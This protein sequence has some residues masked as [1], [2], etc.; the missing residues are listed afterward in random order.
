MIGVMSVGCAGCWLGVEATIRSALAGLPL[1]PSFDVTA[2][3]VFVNVPEEVAVMLTAKLHEALSA[4]VAPVRLTLPA[5]AAA[6]IVPPPQLPLRPLGF[7]STCP[8]GSVSVNPIPVRARLGLGFEMLKV[9]F[10]APFNATLALPYA[11]A[12]MGGTFVGGVCALLADE[13]PHAQVQKKLAVKSKSA[14]ERD[15]SWLVRAVGVISITGFPAESLGLALRILDKGSS[16][17]TD[18][19]LGPSFF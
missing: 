17:D 1:P 4:R 18:L 19:L 11:F 3:V 12:I 8:D 5:P 16:G 7:A 10:V 14:K 2:L 9:R 6:V 13:P 15:V